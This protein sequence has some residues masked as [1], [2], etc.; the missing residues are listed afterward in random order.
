MLKS[1]W[2]YWEN[3][4]FVCG[5]LLI[6]LWFLLHVVVAT[7]KFSSDNTI[8]RLWQR[9]NFVLNKL[10]F[11]YAKEGCFNRKFSLSAHKYAMSHSLRKN[12]SLRINITYADDWSISLSCK[13]L[14]YLLTQ[15]FH[16]LFTTKLS[17]SL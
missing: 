16:K 10:I 13:A 4:N 14:R 7:I 17:S 11:G 9:I 12:A 3:R 15:I 1:S 5:N 6:L 2:F 8:I